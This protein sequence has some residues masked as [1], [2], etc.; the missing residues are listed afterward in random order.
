M[1]SN[2]SN[3]NQ[4]WDWSMVY[5]NYCDGGSFAGNRSEPVVSP[6]GNTLYFRGARIIR[7]VFDDLVTNQGLGVSKGTLLLTGTSAGGL[8]TY[9]HADREATWVPATM[10]V[11][12]VPDAGYFLPLPQWNGKPSWLPYYQQV[13]EEQDVWGSVNDGCMAA[14]PSV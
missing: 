5:I 13:A 4:F 6:A 1:M 14:Y 12:A 10:R 3:V 9:L 8:A 11:V 2:D 7:A